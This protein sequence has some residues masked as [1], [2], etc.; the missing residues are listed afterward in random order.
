[1]RRRT[2]KSSSAGVLEEL[3]RV[4]REVEPD[5][6]ADVGWPG[7]KSVVWSMEDLGGSDTWME[8]RENI[9]CGAMDWDAGSTHI[10]VT[11]S[12][13]PCKLLVRRSSR[14][15]GGLCRMMMVSRFIWSIS[16]R[17]INNIL[18]PPPPPPPPPPHC[19][20]KATNQATDSWIETHVRTTVPLRLHLPSLGSLQH[21]QRAGEQAQ[22]KIGN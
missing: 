22:T 15:T 8:G 19:H 12:S 11:I 14:K 1:M 7:R 5:G 21:D 18:R 2:R 17:R 16:T 6:C 9:H 13:R 3:P 4:R 10:H 20:V